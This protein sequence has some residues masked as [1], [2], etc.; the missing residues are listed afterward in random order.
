[1]DD[2]Y[3]E[4]IHTIRNC[5]KDFTLG[6]EAHAPVT[7]DAEFAEAFPDLKFVTTSST[8]E[9]VELVRFTPLGSVSACQR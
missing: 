4:F 6:H 7:C 2:L 1:M 8:G 9:E 5:H 3:A